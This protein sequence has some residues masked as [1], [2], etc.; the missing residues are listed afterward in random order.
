M[1][2]IRFFVQMEGN[3]THD[4]L[5]HFEVMDINGMKEF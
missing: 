2:D 5:A 4:M 3:A 1:I